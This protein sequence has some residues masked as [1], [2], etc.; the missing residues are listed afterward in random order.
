MQANSGVATRRLDEPVFGMRPCS[1]LDHADAD[2]IL[3]LPQGIEELELNK[4]LPAVAASC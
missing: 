1:S 3:V 2:A 4:I